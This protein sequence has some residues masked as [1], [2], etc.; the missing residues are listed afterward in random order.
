MTR[1]CSQLPLIPLPIHWL[2]L[3]DSL[4]SCSLL[5]GD[6]NASTVSVTVEV[7]QLLWDVT[8]TEWHG[9]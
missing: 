7:M 2:R 5:P 6:I 9:G 8:V 1:L 4:S 3:T